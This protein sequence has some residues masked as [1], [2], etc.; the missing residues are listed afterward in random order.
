MGEDISLAAATLHV[1]D[2]FGVD[3]YGDATFT[4]RDGRSA[5]LSF[6]MDNAYSCALEIIGSTGTAYSNRI[7]TAPDNLAVKVL[8]N[9][10]GD[11]KTINI[12]PF[13]QFQATLF[14]FARLTDDDDIRIAT[15]KDILKHAK[16]VDEVKNNAIQ[17]RYN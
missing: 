5:Q 11:N 13:D 6:G 9:K 3:I 2:R 1:S 7:F 14:E 8:V 16:L 15:G 12:E 17:V 10:K 4:S